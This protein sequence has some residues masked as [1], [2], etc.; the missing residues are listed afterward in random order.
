MHLLTPWLLWALVQSGL[1]AGT[2]Q[3]NDP[4]PGHDRIYCVAATERYLPGDYYFC[5]GNQALQD[6]K[7]RKALEFYETA[8]S[9]GDK[10]AMFNMGLIHF[11]G[12]G[13]PVDQPLGIAWL[14]LAA[15]REENQME[16]EV[17]VGAMKSVSPE[18][19]AQADV[20]WNSM[21]LKYAD[22]I[23]LARSQN[24]YERETRSIR[25]EVRRDPSMSA[26]IAGL[27][28]PIIG[29]G[30]GSGSDP[31]EPMAGPSGSASR[32]LGRMDEAAEE[33]ILRPRKG[34]NGRV[35]TGPLKVDEK[36]KAAPERP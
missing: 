36:K 5:S 1:P 23:A 17:L 13:V 26:W 14:A 22:R 9:W 35:I 11:R 31:G 10:R 2:A 27:A 33:A 24:R 7:T 12:M 21:K 6:G 20:H 18:I 29:S 16:R 3:Q 28:P 25:S 30:I 34:H 32:L 8:A 15:E 4:F 19:R